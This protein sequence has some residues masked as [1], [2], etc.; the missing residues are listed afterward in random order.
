M[1][2]TRKKEYGTRFKGDATVGG[3][4]DS[5]MMSVVRVAM[6]KWQKQSQPTMTHSSLQLSID[7]LPLATATIIN[8]RQTIIL[9]ARR[10]FFCRIST[11][12]NSI[13]VDGLCVKFGGQVESMASSRT[14]PERGATC[15]DKTRCGCCVLGRHF[16]MKVRQGGALAF[17][18]AEIPFGKEVD[19]QTSEHSQDPDPVAVTDA[20]VVFV[21]GGVE[22]LM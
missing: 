6:V 3:W 21:G 7:A 8:K 5:I 15:C 14:S 22:P 20:A 1:S 19:S 11:M 9:R 12:E 2:A 18:I 4:D 17:F 16:G 13:P 10:W